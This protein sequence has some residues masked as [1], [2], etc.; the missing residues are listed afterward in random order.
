MGYVGGIIAHSLCVRTYGGSLIH[1]LVRFAF[2]R[3]P[4]SYVLPP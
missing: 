3:C 2:Q 1:T 4:H